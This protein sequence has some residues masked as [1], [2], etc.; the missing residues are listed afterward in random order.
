MVLILSQSLADRQVVSASERLL[1][2]HEEAEPTEGDAAVTWTEVEGEE[3]NKGIRL[4]IQHPKV[5]DAP[6]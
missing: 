2:S 6:V 5:R 3:L 4:K 1:S